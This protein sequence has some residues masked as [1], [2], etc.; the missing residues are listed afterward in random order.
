VLQNSV[1]NKQLSA[2]GVE[3][4][5][6]NLAMAQILGA[7]GVHQYLTDGT[8]SKAAME[9]NGGEDK[10]RAIVQGRRNHAQALASGAAAGLPP[11]SGVTAKI[12][13]EV[14]HFTNS[15]KN[16]DNL[17]SIAKTSDNPGMKAA[18]N[19]QIANNLTQQRDAAKAESEVA[20]LA[21][22]PTAL[23]NALKA[24]QGEEGSWTKMVLY[25]LIGAKSL[26]QDERNKL[27]LDATWQTK[28][29]DGEDVLVQMKAN[30]QPMSAFYLTGKEAGKELTGTSL[31]RAA[32][33]AGKNVTTGAEVFEDKSGSKYYR[34]SDEK[35]NIRYVEPGGKVY[36]GPTSELTPMRQISAIETKKATVLLQ[37]NKDLLVK[38][39]KAGLD[40]VASTQKMRAETGQPLLTPSELEDLGVKAPDIT[41]LYKNVPTA[42]GAAP[43]GGIPTEASR[44]APTAGGIPTEAPTTAPAPATPAVIAGPVKPQTVSEYKTGTKLKEHNLLGFSKDREEIG[45]AAE[46]G[47]TIVDTK[48]AQTEQL[49]RNPAIIGIMTG[50]GAGSD[51]LRNLLLYGSEGDHRAALGEAITK[52][53]ITDPRIIDDINNYDAQ[54][55]RVTGPL[56]R[57]NLPGIQRITQNEFNAVKNQLLTNIANSTPYAVFQNNS[58]EQFIGDLTRAKNDFVTKNN[59]DTNEKLQ[60]TWPKEQD[61]LYHEYAAIDIARNKWIKDQIGEKPIPTR[62]SDP[63]YKDYVNAVMHSF[64]VFPT[65]EY[66]PQDNSWNYGSKKAEEAAKFGRMKSLL[67]Q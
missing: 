25:G 67:G 63:G 19:Y 33:V 55:S 39:Y 41:R 36:K 32:G 34:Q 2:K 58:R 45:K 3:P 57:Q 28:N 51:A 62:S 8:F 53:G 30:G 46:T 11:P 29:I 1:Y 49:Y 65:P 64:K 9:A 47:Q 54:Q 17:Y 40:A 21:Q 12:I 66:N 13:Q 56:V 6:E 5:P 16:N 31:G 23:A 50:T 37:A 61:K 7:G 60:S 59:I 18:S 10:L 15:L 26:M 52:A 38:D 42:P 22:D 24:K 20:H 44:T 48:R 4:T 14:D 43:A 35:G 27:G